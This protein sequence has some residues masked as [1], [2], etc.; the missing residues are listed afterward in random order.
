MIR[1]LCQV[2]GGDVRVALYREEWW[3]AS[4]R[5]LVAALDHLGA[6]AAASAAVDRARG[7]RFRRDPRAS[8]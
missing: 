8:R 2:V 5:V 6:M 4:P 3:Q 7:R 1:K